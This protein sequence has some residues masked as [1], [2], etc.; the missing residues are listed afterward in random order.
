MKEI[1][2][3]VVAGRVEDR[4]TLLRDLCGDDRGLQAD[5]E[6]LLAADAGSGSVFEV[7]VD[8][9]M[10][11]RVFSAVAGVLDHETP[12]LTPGERFGPYEITGLLGVGGMGLVYRARDTTL[13]RDVALKILPDRLAGRPRS[14]RTLRARGA[15]PGVAQ[16]SQHRVDL[17][18]S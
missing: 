15:R 1:F 14:T 17:R 12:A 9:D 6:S 5:V 4:A 3:A 18:R 7:S 11:G 8:R 13:G 2:D 10:R 16:P